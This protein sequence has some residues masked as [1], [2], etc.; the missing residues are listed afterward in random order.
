MKW[1]HDPYFA[2]HPESSQIKNATIVAG[3]SRSFC[4]IRADGRHYSAAYCYK[5]NG[6]RTSTTVFEV[7]VNGA[8]LTVSIKSPKLFL[9]LTNLLGEI[10]GAVDKKKKVLDGKVLLRNY[11][12]LKEHLHNLCSLESI[13]Q[14][15]HR[16]IE[17]W[18]LLLE[19]FLSNRVAF[20]FFDFQHPCNS[21]LLNDELRESL[22]QQELENGIDALDQTYKSA[23]NPSWRWP[24]QTQKEY[25]LSDIIVAGDL[26]QEDR[27]RKEERLWKFRTDFNNQYERLRQAVQEYHDTFPDP[28]YWQLQNS[29]QAWSAAIATMRRLSRLESSTKLIDALCFLCASRAFAETAQDNRNEYLSAFSQDLSTW[30]KVFPKIKEIS[31]FMWPI[32]TD[33]KPQMIVLIES[34]SNGIQH[35]LG[36]KGLT[37]PLISDVYSVPGLQSECSS[38]IEQLR[39]SVADLLV[40]ANAM[41]GR[42]HS[43]DKQINETGI[44][45]QQWSGSHGQLR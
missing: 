14:T 21:G 36:E 45:N 18:K 4:D 42:K 22:I 12:I 6:W 38:E 43:P 30:N 11:T 2:V 19:G 8:L 29:R 5:C 16:N 39:L 41:F 28:F 25:M 9:E 32:D 37:L 10:L 7:S 17:E 35:I 23:H 1:N 15:S 3:A 33:P 27:I 20:R 24:V 44:L 13:T 34:F 26:I 31:R 40:K